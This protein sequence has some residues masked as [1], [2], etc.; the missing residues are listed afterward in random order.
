MWYKTVEIYVVN[1]ILFELY[2]VYILHENE[3]T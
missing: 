1:E 2:A 3:I